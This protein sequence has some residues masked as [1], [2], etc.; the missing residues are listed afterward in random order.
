MYIN[1]QFMKKYISIGAE[2]FMCLVAFNP[3]EK[4]VGVFF[5]F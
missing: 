4:C 5:K 3:P 2:L 1:V